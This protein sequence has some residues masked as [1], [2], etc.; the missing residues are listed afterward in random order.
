MVAYGLVASL[1]DYYATFVM[2]LPSDP[3]NYFG[4]GSKSFGPGKGPWGDPDGPLEVV[5]R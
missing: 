4:G 1:L 3:T 2:Y 5:E